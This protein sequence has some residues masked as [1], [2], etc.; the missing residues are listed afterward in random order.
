MNVL[1]LTPDAV[2]STL[3]QRLI[4]IYMQFHDYDR[5][6]INLHELTNG[7]EKY[8]SPDFN[9]EIVS[10]RRVQNWGYHQS[11]QEIVELLA[12]VDH[13]KTSRLAQYHIR[14]RG[15]ALEQQ[16]PFYRYLDDNFF[17]ISCRRHNVFEHALSQCINRVTKKLNVYDSREKLNTFVDL[18]RDRMEID[19]KALTATLE[20]YKNYLAWSEDHFSIASYFYYDQHLENIER[21][22][23]NLPIFP[24]SHDRIGWQ[25]TFGIGFDDWN[26]CHCAPGD[27]GSLVLESGSESLRLTYQ[28]IMP[29]DLVTLYQHK[30]L[31][32]WPGVSSQQDFDRLPES[33]RTEFFRMISPEL[34][35]DSVDRA[36]LSHLP[37]HRQFRD[38]HQPGYQRAQQTIQ[39][40]VELDI[41]ISAP[42]IKKQTM[43]EK[44]YLI[45]NFEQCVDT[46][47]AWLENNPGI[48]QPV[49][50]QSLDAHIS[51]E[52]A[53]WRDSVTQAISAG[54]APPPSLR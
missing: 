13:Y 25:D 16:I 10:K 19:Q 14:A 23:L 34:S 33:V 48:A 29:Q 40:M 41:M 30:S 27:I 47:N 31:P 44:Q 26:R 39:R 52:K 53:Y 3:L 21:Y 17:V 12:S 2:G 45:K 5:P 20:A 4:T 35:I 36:V 43:A 50:A 1:I 54:S 51:Q 46:Y 42:P 11:L 22:I 9:R 28:D 32:E 6:V 37:Q 15:D 24:S 38:M 18:Y 49:T 8:F 7:L